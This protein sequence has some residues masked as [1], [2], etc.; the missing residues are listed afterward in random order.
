MKSRDKEHF[1]DRP[2][3]VKRMLRV[4]Y[5]VCAGLL[6]ADF[7]FHRHVVHAFEA[8]PGFYALFGLAACV[9]LVLAAKEM[10]KIL[11]R[12]EDYYEGGGDDAGE[13]DDGGDGGRG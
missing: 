5:A 9:V 4:F 7:L 6:T 8:V 11:M 3:N 2:R 1:F 13:S 10:R 12:G